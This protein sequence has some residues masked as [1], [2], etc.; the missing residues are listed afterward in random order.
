METFY[1]CSLPNTR[2]EPPVIR[3]LLYLNCFKLRT[4]FLSYTNPFQ[5]LK[6]HPWLLATVLGST[7]YLIHHRELNW[8][9]H[10]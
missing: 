8:I 6:S 9:A 5:V 4:Q 7:E 2:V 1:R 10:L 3:D